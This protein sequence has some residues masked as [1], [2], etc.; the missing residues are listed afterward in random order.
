MRNAVGS[1]SVPPSGS[2][3]DSRHVG[4]LIRTHSSSCSWGAPRRQ[5]RQKLW[6]QGNVLGSA[7]RSRHTAQL[8]WSPKLELTILDLVRVAI[9]C[10]WS[11][12][13]CLYRVVISYQLWR[14]SLCTHT[15]VSCM[16]SS[17][18]ITWHLSQH[19]IL[20]CLFT[21]LHFSHVYIGWDKCLSECT[22]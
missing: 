20:C 18:V 9:W 17:T 11:M 13:A 6:W 14:C 8:S 15:T 12:A 5:R 21:I 22:C 7:K 1:W 10:K 16:H 4:H 19:C 3:D 2:C